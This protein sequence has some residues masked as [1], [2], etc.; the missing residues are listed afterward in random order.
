M[1]PKKVISIYYYFTEWQINIKEKWPYLLRLQI[2][3]YINILW[4]FL[5]SFFSTWV[6][7]KYT[8]FYLSYEVKLSYEWSFCFTVTKRYPPFFWFLYNKILSKIS[9]GR[10]FSHRITEVALNF[11]KQDQY[12]AIFILCGALGTVKITSNCVI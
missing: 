12:N 6:G 7:F 5:F 11:E 2:Y 9:S 8:R 4:I 1:L 10:F 3:F